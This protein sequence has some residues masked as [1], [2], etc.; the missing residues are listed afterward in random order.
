MRPRQGQRGG[1]ISLLLVL[2][3]IGLL[4]YFTLRGS[5]KSPSAPGA[6]LDCERRI[7]DLVK[8]TGGIGAAAEVAWQALPDPCKKLMPEPAALAPPVERAPGT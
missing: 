6:P 1:A 3:V 5:A 2:V 8:Q 7:G 4:A